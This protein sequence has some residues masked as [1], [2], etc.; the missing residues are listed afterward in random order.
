MLATW[1]GRPPVIRLNTSLFLKHAHSYAGLPSPPV[2][3]SLETPEDMNQA[4]DWIAR[5][6]SETI[7]KALVELSFSRSSGPGGQVR[8]I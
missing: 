3:H 7:P 2:L 1:L 6:R 8:A 4:R 5:F